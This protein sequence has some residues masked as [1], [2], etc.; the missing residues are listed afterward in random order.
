[1]ADEK[2]AFGR[3][4]SDFPGLN[5]AEKEVVAAARE[6][7][8]ARFGTKVPETD[9]EKGA[10]KIQA[11]LVRF[12]ALGGDDVTPVHER[13]VRVRSAVIH[14]DLDFV[15]CTLVGDLV[16]LD[17]EL[18][19]TLT[20]HGARIR[21]ANLGGSLC[22]EIIA[23]RLEAAGGV[24]L[25][26]GFVAQG[27]VRLLGADIKG[28]LD[29]SNGRFEWTNENG[30]ALHCDGIH[31]G[32]GVFLGDGFAAQGAVRLLG[33][34]IKGNLECG[35]GRFEGR[36]RD[37]DAFICDRIQV[38]GSVFLR[39]G[40][41]AQGVVRLLGAD[42]KRNLDCINGR[43]EGCDQNGIALN[44]ERVRVGGHVFLRNGF[45]TL[46]AVQLLG[47]EVDRDVSC[48]SGTFGAL[49]EKTGAADDKKKKDQE[50]STAPKRIAWPLILARATIRGT[51]W[52]G[53]SR[54]ITRF[55][56]GADLT[57]ASI[58]RIVDTV[59]ADTSR[60][61]QDASP[62]GTGASPC[63]LALDGLTFARFG[64]NTNLGAPARI[65][66][67]RLQREAD[68][69]S[70]F[71]P[72]PW[73]Q[74][75]KVL[76]ESGHSEAAREVAIAYENQRRQ[77]GQLGWFT[78]IFHRIYGWLVGYGH[79]PMRL[80]GIT[81]AMWFICTCMF[82][83]AADVGVMAPTNPR[84]Y[85]GQQYEACRPENLGNWTT[86]KAP[87]EYTTFNAAIYSLDLIL[88]L[89]GLQQEKDWAPMITQPCEQMTYLGICLRPWNAYD[90]PHFQPQSGY[91]PFGLFVWGA[92][93]LEILFGWIAGLLFVAVISGLV[94]NE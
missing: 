28:D 83:F 39:S 78:S 59:K 48:I 66:Y 19:G 93:L 12:L 25:R 82:Y 7:R 57:G 80:A 84:I 74:M 69:G 47:A 4:L 17:C 70:E 22:Q 81:L 85:E 20:L 8:V 35:N 24:F 32:G 36:D 45:A 30:G 33:A 34:D 89:V 90:D 31:V 18:T 54:A 49:P 51:L 87:Y 41:A 79:R 9:A 63:F 1:V 40:F 68:L 10:N 55:H 52:L 43:F 3:S 56:G 86:C 44:C 14:G 42:I 5:D 16:L 23:D 75:V 64:E 21:T 88:P 65:A 91:W 61:E 29:C 38:G 77:A 26:N 60:R 71:K 15:G 6:G 76:R 73:M 92:M 62:A 37:G 94:K 46:G 67:I 72:Q 11:G 27:A 53:D 50:T 13:G 2:R 58:G